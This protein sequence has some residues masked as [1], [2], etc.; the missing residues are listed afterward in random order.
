MVNARRKAEPEVMGFPWGTFYKKNEDCWLAREDAEC[1]NDRAAFIYYGHNI[2]CFD[3]QDPN[4]T[5][6]RVDVW[7]SLMTL[8]GFLIFCVLPV[9]FLVWRYHKKLEYQHLA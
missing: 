8:F 3:P 6:G 7:F 9:L 2:C 1:F 5:C 4:S